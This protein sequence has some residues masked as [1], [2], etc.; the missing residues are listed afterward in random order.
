MLYVLST[1]WVF[2]NT[3]LVLVGVIGMIEF[4]INREKS[5][6]ALLFLICEANK[7]GQEPS[8]YDLVKAVFLA[9]RAHL[10]KCGRPVT[11]DR[12]VAM[13]HGPV[14]SF[15]YDCLKPDFQWGSMGMD[16]APWESEA[17]GKV[18]R[19][20][21][22]ANEP[23]ARKLSDSDRRFLKDAIGTVLSLTFGQIRRLTHDDRAYVAAWRDEEGTNAFPMDMALLLDDNDEGTIEDIKYLAEMSAA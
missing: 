23:D 22:P 7:R 11:Y 15:A 2:D 9:D 17:D 1:L 3:R 21:A 10:N 8:Q 4:Q 18:H 19:F 16:A 12:Y 5:V 13:N 14:P 6:N 20:S